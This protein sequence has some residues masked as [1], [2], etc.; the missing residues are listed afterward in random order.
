MERI[1]SDHGDEGEEEISDHEQDLE[2][3][4]VKLEMP[5]YRTVMVFRKA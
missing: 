4:H 1:A 5:K 3:G 2:D